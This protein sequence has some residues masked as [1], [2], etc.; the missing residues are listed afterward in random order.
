MGGHGAP[1]SSSA[2]LGVRAQ[3]KGPGQAAYQCGP[4]SAQDPRWRTGFSSSPALRQT[5]IS[6]P[7]HAH[8]LAEVPEQAGAPFRTAHEPVA[9]HAP[10]GEKKSR[11]N[12]HVSVCGQSAVEWQERPKSQDTLP[13]APQT[14]S[15]LSHGMPRVHDAPGP[16][17]GAGHNWTPPSV[18][19]WPP[20]GIPVPGIVVGGLGLVPELG[21]VLPLL[22]PLV[23]FPEVGAVLPLLVVEP[24]LAP[25]PELG[26]VP[27]SALEPTAAV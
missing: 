4:G 12:K 10:N 19:V 25:L 1:A 13:S 26:G 9:G 15:G 2:G 8:P 11:W 7:S 22:L 3:P 17:P 14:Q 24:P 20:S 16:G 21:A 23:V 5:L 18:G 6:V 27:P